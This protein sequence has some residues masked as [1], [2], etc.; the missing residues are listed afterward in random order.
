MW[1]QR[2]GV[3][4]E[5]E[6]DGERERSRET[7]KSEETEC[8]V[9]SLCLD[10]EGLASLNVRWRPVVVVCSPGTHW[11]NSDPRAYRAPRPWPPSASECRSVRVSNDASAPQVALHAEHTCIKQKQTYDCGR[12]CTG[13]R[14]TG[15]DMQQIGCSIAGGCLAAT[16]SCMTDSHARSGT[17]TLRHCMAQGLWTPS[18]NVKRKCTLLDSGRPSHETGTAAP[19]AARDRACERAP[20]FGQRAY[21]R[22]RLGPVTWQGPCRTT[23]QLRSCAGVTPEWCA[24]QLLWGRSG[25]SHRSN[26]RRIPEEAAMSLI[27]AGAGCPLCNRARGGISIPPAWAS[28]LHLSMVAAGGCT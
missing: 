4:R 24:C 8:H 9:E 21:S 7:D 3:E 14:C 10:F 22:C 16:F 1:L 27:G 23:P 13:A 6:K 15:G 5:R 19:S 20:S 28:S 18:A 17:Q 2:G 26:S 25:R 11:L 12:S